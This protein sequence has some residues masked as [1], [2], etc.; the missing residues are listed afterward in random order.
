M[1][2]KDKI[3]AHLLKIRNDIFSRTRGRKPAWYEQ[4]WE[5]VDDEHKE[6]F[7]EVVTNV[8]EAIAASGY[9][10]SESRTAEVHPP[11]L[12]VRRKEKRVY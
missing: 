6:A 4:E 10:V 11:I 9:F 8:L 3:A 5:D 1:I 7:I 12:K 2:D